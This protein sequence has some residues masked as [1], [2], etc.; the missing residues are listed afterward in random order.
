MI[1]EIKDVAAVVGCLS[2]IIALMVT[3]IKPLRTGFVNWIKRKSNTCEI[4]KKIDSISR[5]LEDHIKHD[6]DKTEITELQTGALLCIMRDSITAIYYK[7][8]DRGSIPTYARE[9]LVKQYECYH[10]M[11]GNSY[12]DIIYAELLELPVEN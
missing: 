10:A 11:H 4:E 5:L 9:N 12:I 6:A 2:A 3:I 8:M 7:Y 1:E